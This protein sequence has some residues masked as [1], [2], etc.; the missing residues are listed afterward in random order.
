MFSIFT[1]EYKKLIKLNHLLFILVLAL[2]TRFV[3]CVLPAIHEHPYSIEVYK[4]YTARLEG[5][6]TNEKAEYLNNRLSEIEEL[7]AMYDEMQQKY[8]YGEIGLDEYSQYTECY[9]KAKAE[10]STVRYLCNKCEILS[11]CTSFDRQL[12]Y[13]TEW[14]DFLEDNGFDYIMMIAI[15][16]IAV[17]AFDVEYSTGSYSQISTS[18]RGKT[19]LA[20]SKLATVG[21]TVFLLSLM[22][23]AVR[24]GVFI[25]RT[26]LA[27]A[28]MPVGNVLLSDGYGETTLK[29]YYVTDAMLKAEVFVMY[30]LLVCSISTFCK[31]VIF[32]FVISFIVCATPMFIAVDMESDKYA[33]FISGAVLG[34]MYTAKISLPLII[35]VVL[36]KIILLLFVA[37]MIWNRKRRE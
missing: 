35:V 25:Y 26:K 36:I 12:F 32:S 2:L 19:Q 11:Q 10:E 23:S 21:I 34:R 3:C 13:D 18:K 15:L 31:N 29:E 17:P 5:K 20:L 37:V 22:M 24:L 33:Y 9:N 7:I 6:F 30:S 16:C 28:E 27:Y 1:T 14:S 8:T 4:S